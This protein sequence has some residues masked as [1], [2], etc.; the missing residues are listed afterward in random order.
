MTWNNKEIETF[1]EDDSKWTEEQWKKLL[2]EL[3][4][5]GLVTNREVTSLVLGHLNPSQV[6]TSIASKK[7][8]QSHFAPRETWKNVR[9]WH[10]DQSGKCA[11][12]GT[13]L[14]LQADHIVP[15]EEL[16]DEADTLDNLTLR[17][18]RCNVIKRP[19]HLSG[20]LTFQTTESAL[21]WLLFTRRPET[22]EEFE[23]MCREY[24]L[25]MA[26]I[27]F[28]EAWAMAKWL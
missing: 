19:S 22:Y 16:G 25:T 4:R 15:R 11:D 12:C 20:G 24:G 26:N 2:D 27:R 5:N 7:T 13:R 8:F 17:C 1:P 14:E 3:I 9:Q 21:M 18:R 28:Q 10:F 23:K 6:G